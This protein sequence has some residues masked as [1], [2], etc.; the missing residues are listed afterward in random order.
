MDKKLVKSFLEA[1]AVGDACGKATEYCSKDEI[2][3]VYSKIE[4]ILTPER[5]LSHKDLFWGQVTDDTEQNFQ[6]I[7]MYAEKGR[8]NA[9][10][11][12]YCLVDW[13]SDPKVE[14]YIGPSSRSAL[15]SIREGAD[16][17]KAG[18]A[19]ITCGGI[20]RVPAAFL[21]STSETL[22]CNVYECLKP[23]HNTSIAMESAMAY[24]YAL[25]EAAKK[26]CTPVSIMISAKNGAEIGKRYGSRERLT[27]V[28]PSINRR[29]DFIMKENVGNMAERDLKILIYDVLGATMASYDVASAVFA[30]FLY[31]KNDVSL[32]IRLA[33]EIGGDSDT[34]ACLSAALCTLYAKG[35][36]IDKEEINLVSK[37]N[38]IDFDELA[39]L[40]P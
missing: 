15:L 6:L 36:N 30:L 33:T 4:T 29:I 28:G 31:A 9:L 3:S 22:E 5:S 13:L 10:D 21:F 19:G 17:D 27:G 16:I 24:A 8:V 14:K 32:A 7:K 23:T 20:M 25:K 18:V 35:H 26:N 37:A 12:A 38:S 34:I 1:I 2:E 39:S 40:I 11:T